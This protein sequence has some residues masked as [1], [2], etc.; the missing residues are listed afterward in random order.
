MYRINIMLTVL[1]IN[2]KLNETEMLGTW[3]KVNMAEKQQL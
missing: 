1:H 2:H 3:S